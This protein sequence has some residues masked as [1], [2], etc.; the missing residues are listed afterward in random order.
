MKLLIE[1]GFL[2]LDHQGG[3]YQKN[4]ETE[5]DYNRYRLSNRWKKYDLPEFERVEKAKVLQP[6]HRIQENIERKKT[7]LASL[8]RTGHVHKSE[9][10]EVKQPGNRV[11]KSE[12]VEG[13]TKTEKKPV[14]VPNI[15][16]SPSGTVLPLTRVHKSER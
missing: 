10:E 9:R 4:N 13:R 14:A 7:R 5:K 16:H 12:R 11:H 6:E 3:W 15:G 8:P 1:R 2:D